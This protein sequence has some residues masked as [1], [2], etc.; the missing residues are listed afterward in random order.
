MIP[1]CATETFYF[2]KNHFYRQHFESLNV[3]VQFLKYGIT[4]A[5]NANLEG[6]KKLN[7]A[8]TITLKLPEFFALLIFCKLKVIVDLVKFLNISR[9]CGVLHFLRANFDCCFNSDVKILKNLG[10][11]FAVSY[12]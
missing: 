1:N 6:Q 2:L 8:K 3:F 11:F 10:Y 9:P 5:N 7:V 12:L 4:F